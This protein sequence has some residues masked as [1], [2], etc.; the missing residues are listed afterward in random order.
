[1][2]WLFSH[3]DVLRPEQELAVQV[4]SFYEVHVGHSDSTFV[5]RA[6]ADEGKVLQEFTADGTGSHLEIR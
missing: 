5:S 3:P 6:Q 4:G 2:R 1:M